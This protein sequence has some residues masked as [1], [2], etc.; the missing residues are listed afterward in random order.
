[1][2]EIII[3]APGVLKSLRG[4]GKLTKEQYNNSVDI[5]NQALASYKL[6]NQALQAAISAGKDPGSVASYTGAL[7]KFLLD[8][9]VLNNIITVTG[10]K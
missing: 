7:T 9:D 4:A 1:M 5:Y 2:G 3:T 6:L 10:G 8:R